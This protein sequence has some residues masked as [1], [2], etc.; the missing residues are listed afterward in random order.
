MSKPQRQRAVDAD[1]L[2]RAQGFLSR[3]GYL[4][5]SSATGRINKNTAQALRRFQK[6]YGLKPTGKFDDSTLKRVLVYRC[7]LPDPELVA[8]YATSCAWPIRA[9]TYAFENGSIDLPD[10][11]SFAAV[12][13]GFSTWTTVVA[14][15][16]S[17]VAMNQSPDITI[18]WRPA[19][20]TDLNMVG[21]AVAHAD[22]P[23]LCGFI[24]NLL[25]RPVHFDDTEC[26]WSN[27]AV[28]GA[29]D[30]ETVA[31]HEIGHILG[32]QHSA[33][34]GAVMAPTVSANFTKRNLTQDDIDGIQSLYP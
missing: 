30:V 16:F 12:R 3:F 5:S 2:K 24:N 8:R 27:G 33:V 9:L 14:V 10:A 6:F 15:T 7:G 13:R 29:F 31:L 26:I 4:E 21:A 11:D 32:L 19:N 17:E 20:D 23:P 25:P 1:Y 22:Y 18:S 34:S 28:P